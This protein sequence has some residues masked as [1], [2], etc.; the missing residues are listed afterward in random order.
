V[1]V[2]HL[3]CGTMRPLGGR[4]INGGRLPLLPARMVCHCLLVETGERLVLVDSGVG[5]ADIQRL[6]SARDILREPRRHAFATFAVRPRLDRDETAVRQVEQ[7]GHAPED[8]TDVVLTH[9]DWDHA[10][11]MGDF[12][13]ATVHV[14]RTEHDAALS[15]ED[16][17]Y[18]S[19]QWEHDPDWVTYGPDGGDSWFGFDGVHALQGLP[20]L[21]LVPLPGH[22]V[23]HCG[24]AIEDGGAEKPWLLHAADAYFD[25]REVDAERPRTPPGLAGFQKRMASDDG[26]R[27]ATR[28][29]VREL[30]ARHGDDVETICCHDPVELERYDAPV[31]SGA[32]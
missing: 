23:G 14:H 10:G 21:A 12:P 20:G 3:N 25:H 13:D 22:T 24:V 17:R 7:L 30:R 1:K 26:A 15:G 5:M 4:M 9:M 32:T 28:D 19:Y 27:R 16:A 11:G 2:H 31:M 29:A 6:R 8:V 18:W